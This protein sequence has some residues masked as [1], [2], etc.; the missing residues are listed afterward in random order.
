MSTM[1]RSPAA[2]R[3]A[4]RRDRRRRRVRR[5]LRRVPGI[6]PWQVEALERWCFDTPPTKRYMQ[7]ARGSGTVTPGGS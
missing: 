2:H 1:G 6:L 7:L 5:I 3:L 4:T